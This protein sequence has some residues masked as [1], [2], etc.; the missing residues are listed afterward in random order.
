MLYLV[1]TCLKSYLIWNWVFVF[2]DIDIIEELGQLFS[3]VFLN[4]GLFDISSGLDSVYAFLMEI[5]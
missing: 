5:P 3:R 1:I 4:S 2:H